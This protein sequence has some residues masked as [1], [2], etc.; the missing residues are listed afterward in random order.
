MGKGKEGGKGRVIAASDLGQAREPWTRNPFP[1][2]PALRR[3]ERE[4]PPGRPFLGARG[5][6]TPPPRRDLF[7]GWRRKLSGKRVGKGLALGPDVLR[8]QVEVLQASQGLPFISGQDSCRPRTHTTVA[9][10][11]LGLGKQCPWAKRPPG[12]RGGAGQRE[13]DN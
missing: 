13:M 9:L 8:A 5:T 4:V 3:G 2:S 7:W 1:S 12:G 11:R 10:R 6:E